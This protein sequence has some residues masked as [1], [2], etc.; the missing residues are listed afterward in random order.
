VEAERQGTRR[1]ESVRREKSQKTLGPLA[2]SFPNFILSLNRPFPEPRGKALPC[3]PSS[4]II[5]RTVCASSDSW[6]HKTP[7]K[8]GTSLTS[9]ALPC[10][11]KIPAAAGAYWARRQTGLVASHTATLFQPPLSRR[12]SQLHPFPD[13]SLDRQVPNSN[14]PRLDTLTA[15]IPIFAT[16]STRNQPPNKQTSS[17][18]SP[19]QD[20]HHRRPQDSAAHGGRRKPRIAA[21]RRRRRG[22]NRLGAAGE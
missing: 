13:S 15:P 14:P 5:F 16:H 1:E 6:R 22:G 12:K 20:A 2:D 4:C 8:R 19:Q 17:T 18:N 11:S 10:R 21:D 7:D 9:H 3:Q